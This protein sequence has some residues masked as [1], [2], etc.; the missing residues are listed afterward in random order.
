[1][2]LQLDFTVEID[3]HGVVLAVTH[4]VPR[5]FRHERVRNAGFSRVLAQMSFRKP[6]FIWE[7]WVEA[8]GR[9]P[10]LR[11]QRDDGYFVSVPQD[12]GRLHQ[13]AEL[14]A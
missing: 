2:E 7:M 3:A 12:E 1:M 8:T 14:L 11:P 6:R 10:G 5:S 4:C 9:L 13:R